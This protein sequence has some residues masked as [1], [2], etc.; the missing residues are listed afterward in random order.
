MPKI[1]IYLNPLVNGLKPAYKWDILGLQ[2]NYQP[3]TNFLGHPSTPPL[4]LNIAGISID[5]NSPSNV[6]R[7]HY[8]PK[9]DE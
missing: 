6:T 9:N 7:L 2:P 4:P 1:A 3:F 8:S 5:F